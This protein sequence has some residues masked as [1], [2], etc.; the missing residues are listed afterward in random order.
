MHQLW[1]SFALV[2][3]VG[4]IGQPA[5]AQTPPQTRCHIQVELTQAAETQ[6]GGAL[7]SGPTMT[8]EEIMSTMKNAHQV[9]HPQHDGTFSMAPNKMNHVE[10]VYSSACGTRVYVYNAFTMPINVD[11]FLAF[12]EFVPLDDDQFEVI[13][14]LQP[15][16]DGSYLGTDANP[17]VEPPFD[18]RLFM[19]FPE[20]DQVELF[21]V[22]LQPARPQFVEGTGIVVEIDLAAGKLVINHTAI[23]GYMGAMTMPYAVSSP[24]VLDRM[25]PGMQIKFTIDREK[26]TIV[27]IDPIV[28]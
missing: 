16:E 28:G 1:K 24:N 3:S 11:R 2:A 10:V 7:Y 13:R 21:T 25:E 22:K 4:L 23:P 12:V 20:S 19:K 27:K 6:L 17:G 14:F 18:I 8:P 26:N 9:H 15:S 5:T